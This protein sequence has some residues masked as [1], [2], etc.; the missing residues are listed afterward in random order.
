MHRRTLTVLTVLALTAAGCGSDATSDSAAPVE[1]GWTDYIAGPVTVFA[2]ASLTESFTT[3]AAKFEAVHPGIRV[4][5][6]FGASSA[7]ALQITQGAPADVFASA[8][9]KNM[10][11]VID[12]KAASGSQTFARNILEIA[13]PPANPAG[14]TG[15]ADLARSG[16]KVA[17]CQSQVPCGATAQ[18][19]FAKA[20]LTV[21][22]VT[23]EPDV[24]A[25]LT[26]VETNEVDAA[27]VYV[28]DVR[29]AG[30]KVKGIPIPDAQNASTD[31]PIARLA[32][33]GNPDGAYA[34]VDYVLSAAGR[35][36]LAAAGFAAP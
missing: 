21:K 8:S 27:V 34:F 31:Y 32:E 6:N 4:K 1:G 3:L 11:Q 2:A 33:A 7:L 23:L 17:L 5:L 15:V 25:A 35:D 28:T 22:P 14:V 9:A 29:A 30:A 36:V 12:A 19:V 18:Q 10:T 13:V 16:V 24:K 26:K 20:G